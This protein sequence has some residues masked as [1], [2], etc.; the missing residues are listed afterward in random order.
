MISDEKR[1]TFITEQLR[2]H[3]EKILQ[4][5]GLYVKLFSGIIGGL[6]WLYTQENIDENIKQDLRGIAL[7]LIVLIAVSVGIGITANIRSWWE[8]RK[9]E[10]VL[11]GPQI[12]PGPKFRSLSSELCMFAVIIGS[13]I[14]YAKYWPF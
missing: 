3:N 12:L 2:Y 14:I 10:S 4:A 5:F 11:V 13:V 8:Y 6:I 9:V 7:W 1:Y